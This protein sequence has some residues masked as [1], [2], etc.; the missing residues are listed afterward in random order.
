MSEVIR[1][2]LKGVNYTKYSEAREF[3]NRYIYA[4]YRSMNN[5]ENRVNHIIIRVISALKGYTFSLQFGCGNLWK[6]ISEFVKLINHKEAR[7]SKYLPRTPKMSNF[8]LFQFYLDL[9][10]RISVTKSALFLCPVR[11]L[12]TRRSITSSLST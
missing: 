11:Q 8:F 6:R 10:N 9:G 1:D 2:V 12:N 5:K 4:I 7:T 3:I